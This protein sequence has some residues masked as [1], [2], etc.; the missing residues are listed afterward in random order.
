MFQLTIQGNKVAVRHKE[1]MTVGSQ[2]YLDICCE[3]DEAWD[4]CDDIWV[5][6]KRNNEPLFKG[7]FDSFREA[8][9]PDG[10]IRIPSLVMAREGPVLI[11]FK[12]TKKTEYDSELVVIP[13][14]W[15]NLGMVVPSVGDYDKDP[16]E[17]DIVS[18]FMG[19]TGNVMP[20]PGDYTPGM[21]G[22]V[23]ITNTK[24][25]ELLK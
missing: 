14:T 19:R 21:V 9:D 25:E 10:L 1:Q 16:P 24:L 20:E 15:A 23:P 4:A 11:G 8:D 7:Y 5:Y 12:G 13:T 18:S 3:F 22:V 6:F 2:G 17:S